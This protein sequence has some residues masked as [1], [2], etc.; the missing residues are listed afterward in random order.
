VDG[1]A[2]G[3]PLGPLFANIFMSHFERKHATK[4]KELGI[5]LWFRYVDDIFATFTRNANLNDIL[6]Y[7]NIQHPNI[8]FTIENEIDNKLPFLDT[9]VYRGPTKYNTTMFRK[10][11]FTGV[12]LNWTS[13]TAKRYKIGL[14]YCLLDRIWKICNEQEEKDREINKLRKILAD[15]EY[16]NHIIE[17][18]IDRFITN[19]KK[20]DQSLSQLY[21]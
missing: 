15:N 2:M 16:P 1:V 20:N 8:E 12:Y 4:L 13:L 9:T 21:D 10:K 6:N 18:E 5:N 3:S 11:T 19:R 7:L 17:K 14:I